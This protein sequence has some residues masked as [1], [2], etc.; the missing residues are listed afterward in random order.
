MLQRSAV[1]L[2]QNIHEEIAIWSASEQATYLCVQHDSTENPCVAHG[3]P[4][5]IQSLLNDM[6]ILYAQVIICQIAFAK[7]NEAVVISNAPMYVYNTGTKD[8][9][10]PAYARSDAGI[11]AVSC[12]E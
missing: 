11:L 5:G 6:C 8:G 12:D 3:L 1:A 7:A 4:Q 2:Q 10:V 9:L